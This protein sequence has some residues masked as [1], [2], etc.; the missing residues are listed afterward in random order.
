MFYYRSA[1]SGRER[2][3]GR[4]YSFWESSM[5]LTRWAATLTLL[6]V[7]LAG[8]QKTV[9]EEPA[10]APMPTSQDKIDAAKARY[11]AMPG[12][13]VGEVD[14]TNGDLTAVS[15]LDPKSISK[16]DVLTFI[17]VPSDE[18]ISHGTLVETKP[19]GRLIV[20]FDPQGK[21]APKAGDLCVK[22]KQ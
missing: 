1:A 14:A 21:R 7:T 8:C 10:P 4:S 2:P 5:I 6:L 3:G 13:M 9:K 12:V 22:L 16:D 19:S 15:G 11:A 18:V 20:S 17:D